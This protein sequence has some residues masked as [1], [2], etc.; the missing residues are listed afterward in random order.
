MD[1]V[2]KNDYDLSLL[3]EGDIPLIGATDRELTILGRTKKRRIRKKYTDRIIRR[4]AR[5]GSVNSEFGVRNSELCFA[6]A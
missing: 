6:R 2:D 4:S 5:A 1:F 3:Q